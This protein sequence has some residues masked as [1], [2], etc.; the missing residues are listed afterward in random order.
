MK[1]EACPKVYGFPP[2]PPGGGRDGLGHSPLT[3]DTTFSLTQPRIL[4]LQIKQGQL[5]FLAPRTEGTTP[6]RNNLENGTRLIK[7]KWR[8]EFKSH[9][10]GDLSPG[11]WPLGF[12]EPF[13]QGRMRGASGTG[14][15]HGGRGL[16]AGATKGPGTCIPPL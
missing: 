14:R 11:A 13:F 2:P 10:D 9:L 16:D 7:E 6:Q 4:P 8:S 1:I 15:E 12:P 5:S 3:F